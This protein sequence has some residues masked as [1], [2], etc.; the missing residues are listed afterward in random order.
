MRSCIKFLSFTLLFLF[1]SMSKAWSE[2]VTVITP[3]LA[4]PGTQMYVE[5]FKEEATKKG[6]DINIIDTKGDVAEV[7]SRI[8]D[9][10]NQKV[11]GI[12]INVD[13][14]QIAAG[15]EV[16]AAANILKEYGAND[17]YCSVVHPLLSGN[18][19]EKLQNSPMKEVLVTNTLPLSKEK[20]F[21]GLKILPIA[22]LLGE[23]IHRIHTGLSVGAMFEH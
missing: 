14:S 20:Q 17:I 13:P 11:D 6:W 10:V 2:K 21:D 19:V 18:A 23:A 15:L 5:G 8:E 1:L 12:V 4:Q 22:S 3:Y 7:I 9:A 16:A